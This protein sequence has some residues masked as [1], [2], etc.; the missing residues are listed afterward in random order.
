MEIA[1]IK[2]RLTMAQVLSHYNLKPDKHLRLCCPFHEDKTPSFQVYYKTHTAYCFS[3]NCPTHGKSLDVID[4]IMYQEKC[5]KHE[6]IIK[7][8]EMI[9]FIN[10]PIPQ[11]KPKPKPENPKPTPEE[12]AVFLNKMFTYFKNAVYNSKPAQEYIQGRKLDFTKLDI[13]YNSGQFHHGARKDETLINQCLQLGLLNDNNIKARTGEPAYNVFGK[14]CIV[15]ALRN[16]QNHVT[17]LYFRST[18]NDKGQKHYY[19]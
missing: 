15:F 12:K 19:L 1:E 11:Q 5:T 13:G 6:A 16:K 2:S 17:G 7:A 8:Q 10:P 9:G 14:T 3:S 4:F 18:I